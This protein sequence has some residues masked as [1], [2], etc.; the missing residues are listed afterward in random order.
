MLLAAVL[1]ELSEVKSLLAFG[2]ARHSTSVLVVAVVP[3]PLE[4]ETK[5]FELKDASTELAELLQQIHE[6]GHLPQ[7]INVGSTESD[8]RHPSCIV[9]R[10]G[11]SHDDLQGSQEVLGVRVGWG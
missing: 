9:G 4:H 11:A 3:A 1:S 2:T 10:R 7:L 6:L 8:Q 5:S